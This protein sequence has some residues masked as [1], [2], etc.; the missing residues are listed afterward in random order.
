MRMA[1]SSSGGLAGSGGQSSPEIMYIFCGQPLVKTMVF[2]GLAAGTV[3]F[4]LVSVCEPLTYSTY[5]T[6][7]FSFFHPQ[8]SHN[9]C[10]SHFSSQFF[11]DVL[12]YTYFQNPRIGTF[13]YAIPCILCM[14]VVFW[15]STN[16]HVLIATGLGLV[17]V[18][19]ALYAR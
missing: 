14:C 16:T 15:S 13:W 9:F 5:I 7:S 8:H 18:A 11:L 1:S 4:G 12:T 10:Y 2:H 17:G 6:H 19:F 3:I